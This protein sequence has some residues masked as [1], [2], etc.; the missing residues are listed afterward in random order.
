MNKEQFIKLQKGDTLFYNGDD[1]VVDIIHEAYQHE[2]GDSY[3][4]I[5]E[6]SR[7]CTIK[8]IDSWLDEVQ[9]IRASYQDESQGY[10]RR[11]E[12]YVSG[13]GKGRRAWE[14]IEASIEETIEEYGGYL[15]DVDSG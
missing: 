6:D 12:F 9:V 1:F 5:I 4:Y 15:V 8:I 11:L 14:F 10:V 7:G 13:I 3:P 2:F